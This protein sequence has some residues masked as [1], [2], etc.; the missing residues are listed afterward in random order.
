MLHAGRSALVLGCLVNALAGASIVARAQSATAPQ[1]DTIIVRGPPLSFQVASI[2]IPTALRSCTSLSYDV[3][4]TGLIRLLSSRSGQVATGKESLL[5]TLSIASA[6]PRGRTAAGTVRFAGCSAIADSYILADVDRVRSIVIEAVGAPSAA[7]A[8]ERLVIRYRLTNRGNAADTSGLELTVPSG[9]RWRLAPRLTTLPVGATA[10]VS[11]ALDVPTGLD[12]GTALVTLAALA[13]TDTLG[14]ASSSFTVIGTRART[15]DGGPLLTTGIAGGR[16]PDGKFAPAYRLRARGRLTEDIRL[17][18]EV[19][20]G[21]RSSDADRALIGVGYWRARARLSLDA[22]TWSLGLGQTGTRFPDITGSTLFGQGVSAQL[23]QDQW[24]VTTLAAQPSSGF[25]SSSGE[26]AAAMADTRYAGALL[27][28]AAAHLSERGTRVRQLDAASTRATF[29]LPDASTLTAELGHRRYDGGAG[30]AWASEYQRRSSTGAF[31]ARAVNAPGGTGAFAR[32]AEEYSL[33][34]YQDVA[35]RFSL[36]TSAWMTRDSSAGWRRLTSKGLSLNPAVRVAPSLTFG[37]DAYHSRY[38]ADGGAGGIDNGESRLAGLLDY[39]YAMVHALVSGGAKTLVRD[40]TSQSGLTSNA[41]VRRSEFRGS[42]A[43]EGLLGWAQAYATIERGRPLGGLPPEY[44]TYGARVDRVPLLPGSH[45]VLLSGWLGYSK[46]GTRPTLQTIRFGTVA[47]LPDMLRMRVYAERNP[48]LGLRNERKGWM[49]AIS[50]ERDLRLPRVPQRAVGTVYRDDNGNGRRDDSEPGVQG[51]IVKSSGMTAVTNHEGKYRFARRARG[52]IRIDAASVPAP[53]VV[54]ATTVADSSRRNVG[55][56][57]VAAVTVH[58][59][60]ADSLRARVD[61]SV[62]AG[63]SVLARD[64]TGR[65]WVARHQ[66]TAIVTLTGLPGG[67][68]TLVVD[69]SAAPEP[70]FVDGIIP[71]LLI[72]GGRDTPEVTIVLRPRAL[73]IREFPRTP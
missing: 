23:H 42:V 63:V 61:T 66:S 1:G 68:Y 14:L 41:L 59:A 38:S 65:T 47:M 54:P 31:L 24:N 5:L 52:V 13:G 33:Y 37:I 50:I 26:L 60:I 17:D 39:R 46:L 51:V 25:G 53:L 55:L 69:A 8:G 45:S 7:E 44:V 64:S 11:A 58:L 15:R 10:E 49:A 32:A 4:P 16:M 27:G 67:R 35:S 29:T 30:V 2:P 21:A 12:G 3:R 70:L 20:L 19:P 43:T 72:V 57:T 34:G 62:L 6:A 36:G 28:V 40:I 22:P 48:Y 73:R 18:G 71:D 56:I 9:W